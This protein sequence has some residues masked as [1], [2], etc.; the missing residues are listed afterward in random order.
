MAVVFVDW[1]IMNLIV[2]LNTLYGSCHPRS[3]GVGVGVGD[4]YRTVV[5]GG[6]YDD[7]HGGYDD[8]Y[9]YEATTTVVSPCGGILAPLLLPTDC[10]EYTEC[11]A[12][13]EEKKENP[14]F[15]V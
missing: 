15:C 14:D 1:A 9:E 8:D 2:A 4:P 11:G 10:A 3:S 13:E 6:G 12:E 5:S 7:D